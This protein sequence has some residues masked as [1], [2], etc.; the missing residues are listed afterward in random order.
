MEYSQSRGEVLLPLLGYIG[1][2]SVKAEYGFGPFWPEIDS[3]LFTLILNIG[4]FW[5]ETRAAN[6]GHNL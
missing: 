6:K 3:G 4:Y 5:Q 2:Y 1:M